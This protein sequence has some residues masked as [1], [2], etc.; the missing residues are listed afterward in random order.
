M[1]V[2]KKVV[3]HSLSLSRAELVHLRD[4]M[5]VCIPSETGQTLSAMLAASEG[6]E[7]VDASL[8]EKVSTLCKTIGV[9]LEDDAPDYV[10]SPISIP[11]MNI[12][13]LQNDDELETVIEQAKENFVFENLKDKCDEQKISRGTSPVCSPK[14]ADES[15]IVPSRRGTKKKD[16]KR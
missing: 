4:I 1:N 11:M 16:T 15:D 8:W 14:Q 12:F 2:E 9:H 3:K 10:I 5:G 13:R 7:A 6:R